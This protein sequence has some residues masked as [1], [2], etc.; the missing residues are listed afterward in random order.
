M[1]TPHPKDAAIPQTDATPHYE[2]G[3]PVATLHGELN[4]RLGI[5]SDPALDIQD[6]S[7]WSEKLIRGFSRAMGPVLLVA[8]CYGMA[9]LLF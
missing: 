9:R 2:A 7:H 3:G 8:T 5:I 1:P 4:Q 6:K